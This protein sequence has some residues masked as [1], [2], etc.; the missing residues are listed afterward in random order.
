MLHKR[1]KWFIGV[2]AVIPAE[3]SESRNPDSATE[4]GMRRR[5]GI[6]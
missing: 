2:F 5:G 1:R 3:R 6:V 4:R